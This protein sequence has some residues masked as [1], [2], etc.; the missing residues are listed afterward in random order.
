MYPGSHPRN[1]RKGWIHRRGTRRWDAAVMSSL[2]NWR[3]LAAW[4]HPGWPSSC[5]SPA[6]SGCTGQPPAAT[7][8]AVLPSVKFRIAPVSAALSG[9]GGSGVGLGPEPRLKARRP[10]QPCTVSRIDPAPIG[11][12]EHRPTTPRRRRDLAVGAGSVW[13]GSTAAWSGSTCAPGRIRARISARPIYFGS[14]VTF[15]GSFVWTGNDDE[16]NRSG[17]V[18]KLDPKTLKVMARRAWDWP[19]G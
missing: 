15:G 11:W 18:S 10:A 13:L 6:T 2:G 1:E 7:P 9:G 12:S 16:R 4:L 19:H 3:Q 8:T 17:S 5:S 14:V